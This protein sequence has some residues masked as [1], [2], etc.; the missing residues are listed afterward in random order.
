MFTAFVILCQHKLV[1]MALGNDGQI[2]LADKPHLGISPMAI[3]AAIRVRL[4]F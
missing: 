4:I 2:L 3:G 1:C